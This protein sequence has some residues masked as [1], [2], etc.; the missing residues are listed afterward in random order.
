MAKSPKIEFSD[1]LL[2]RHGISAV[3]VS[4]DVGYQILD[5]GYWISNRSETACF[6]YPESSI[7]HPASPPNEFIIS[8]GEHWRVSQAPVH[9]DHTR[10]VVV[11][12]IVPDTT[13]SELH[14]EKKTP[15]QAGS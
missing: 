1:S 14:Q 11:S 7:R 13:R 15:R 10:D 12:Q 5:T 9:L 3:L 8:A 4:E 2:V 6:P